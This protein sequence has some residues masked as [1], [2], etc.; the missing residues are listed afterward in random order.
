MLRFMFRPLFKAV[1]SLTEERVLIAGGA[2]RQ[3]SMIWEVVKWEIEDDFSVEK[4]QIFCQKCNIRL[5]ESNYS[6]RNRF[7]LDSQWAT[8]ELKE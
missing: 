1:V 2:E 3:R 7:E 6:H 8:S 4:F 5:P